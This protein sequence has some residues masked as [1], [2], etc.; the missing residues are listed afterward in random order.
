MSLFGDRMASNVTVCRSPTRG[1][2]CW[3][4]RIQPSSWTTSP[5]ELIH[6]LNF[7][8]IFMKRKHANGGP[9]ISFYPF[10]TV[11]SRA[12]SWSYSEDVL[13]SPD[14]SR[15]LCKNSSCLSVCVFTPCWSAGTKRV[16]NNIVYNEYISYREHVHM[17]STQWETL[18]DFTKWLG[19][20][21]Q[22]I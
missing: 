21:G 15:C 1:S 13:V 11:S 14:S 16:H 6:C 5:S 12:T 8:L 4:Q 17:N 19:R 9:L 2:Y 7:S 10:I 22:L 18:T 20:E 3:P